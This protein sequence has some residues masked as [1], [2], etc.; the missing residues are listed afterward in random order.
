[1]R[2]C[3]LFIAP[4]IE[5]SLWA[6]NKAMGDMT[7]AARVPC[8]KLLRSLGYLFP[9]P[10][11]GI[12]LAFFSTFFLTFL[13]FLLFSLYI[14][15][16]FHTRSAQRG[17]LYIP[18]GHAS[19]RTS[20]PECYLVGNQLCLHNFNQLFLS[21]NGIK[22]RGYICVSIHNMNSCSL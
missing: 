22:Y 6:K 14:V 13:L 1:M 8:L 9:L 3:V 17:P 20:K 19:E 15:I 12:F 21:S 16:F 10:R 18:Y 7:R 5:L 2:A 11:A 4:P